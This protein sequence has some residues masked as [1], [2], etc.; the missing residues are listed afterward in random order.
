M[1][2]AVVPCHGVGHAEQ[3]CIT[4]PSAL[5]IAGDQAGYEIIAASWLR[6]VMLSLGKIRYRCEPT[7]RGDRKSC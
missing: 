5:K 2:A 1:P 3:G 6:E 4:A 7:V